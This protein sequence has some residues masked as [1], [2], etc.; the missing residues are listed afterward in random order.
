MPEE[1]RGMGSIT[2]STF[3][4]YL[5]SG[6]MMYVLLYIITAV[7]AQV[8]LMYYVAVVVMVVVV[9]VVVMSMV[10]VVL[11]ELVVVLVMLMLVLMVLMLM[12]VLHYLV[13]GVGVVH[14]GGG[15][16]VKMQVFSSQILHP[17]GVFV[18]RLATW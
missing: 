8:S 16:G 6:G 5:T 18:G 15:G 17:I 1:E 12:L 4:I 14:S 10:H 7:M 2:R 13:L 11:M 9:M 3:V